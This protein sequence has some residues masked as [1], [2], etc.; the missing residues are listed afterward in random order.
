MHQ[1]KRTRDA[2]WDCHGG[3]V[4]TN[5]PPEL[6]DVESDLQERF[7]L[8]TSA[9]WSS[10]VAAQRVALAHD[11]PLWRLGFYAETNALPTCDGN[12]TSVTLQ[13]GTALAG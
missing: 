13:N 4:T 12:G 1:P 11:D 7:P 5:N 10:H 9:D 8:L 2:R 6:L 3:S